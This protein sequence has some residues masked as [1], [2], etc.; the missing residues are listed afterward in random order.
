M[1]DDARVPTLAEC[2]HCLDVADVLTR[3]ATPDDGLGAEEARRRLAVHGSNELQAFARSSPW[4]ALGSQFKNV[5]VVNLRQAIVVATGM[6][7]E[8][9]QNSRLVQTVLNETQPR[10]YEIAF[11]SERRRMRTL[12]ASGEDLVAHSKGAVDVVLPDCVAWEQGG[13][14]VLLEPSH[15][16]SILARE[17]EMAAGALRVLALAR[18]R[19]A[20]AADVE[21][22]ME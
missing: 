6:A 15:R 19:R 20:G 17:R 8:F 14:I 2:W 5:L 18:K 4:H 22:A 21:T 3:L 16:E 12:H 13:R 11:T 9:G 7:T 10:K 1:P